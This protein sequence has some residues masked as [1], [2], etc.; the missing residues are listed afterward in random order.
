MDNINERVVPC[1]K[2][3]SNYCYETIVEGSF[4]S[5]S[6]LLC[7][8]ATNTR[9][10]NNTVE[11]EAYLT[12]LPRLYQD[13]TVLDEDGFVWVPRYINVPGVGEIYA[14]VSP[15]QDGWFWT[16]AKHIPMPENEKELY[17]NPDGSYREYKADSMNAKHFH[18]EAFAGALHYLGLI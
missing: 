10:L 7:G 2:C 18:N 15:Q 5:W 3:G 9:M 12:T 16:A 11:L 13:L 8:Y 4:V 14:N 1:R 6:C 17:K